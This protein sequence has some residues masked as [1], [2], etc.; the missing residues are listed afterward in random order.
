VSSGLS[1]LKMNRERK[2]I[3]IVGQAWRYK[4]PPENQEIF[5]GCFGWV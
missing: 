3:T 2:K 5:C 1:V 4:Y